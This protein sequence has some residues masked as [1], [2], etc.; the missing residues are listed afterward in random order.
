VAGDPQARR[1]GGPGLAGLVGAA[2]A[3]G[4]GGE[5]AG[6]G[7]DLGEQRGGHRPGQDHRRPVRPGGVGAG[8][9]GEVGVQQIPAGGEQAGGG[10][11]V[12]GHG[13]AGRGRDGGRGGE[14]GQGAGGGPLQGLA[15]FGGGLRLTLLGWGQGGVERVGQGQVVQ[16]AG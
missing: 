11:Q 13:V 16:V 14:G 8:R 1:G 15:G 5:L 10:G 7:A 2:Q 9:P 6:D 4:P 3:G 12:G